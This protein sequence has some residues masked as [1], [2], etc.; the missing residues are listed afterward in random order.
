V[1]FGYVTSLGRRGVLVLL[2]LGALLIWAGRSDAAALD[3][4]GA[5]APLPEAG[6]GL[7]RPLEPSAE[8][9][10]SG[11]IAVLKVAAGDAGALASRLADGQRAEL[12]VRIDGEE[13]LVVELRSVNLEDPALEAVARRLLDDP[14]R[15]R[16]GDD[17]GIA[18]AAALGSSGSPPEESPEAAPGVARPAL[19]LPLRMAGPP[20]VRA[21]IPEPASAALLATG[22]IGLVLAS[23]RQRH[24]RQD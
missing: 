3:P 14:A 7:I 19:D 1:I 15:I 6:I 18:V 21:A 2:A 13:V 17:G 11:G 24:P 4:H 16:I 5:G 23:R 12:V 8:L 9:T 10:L 22:L 20:A